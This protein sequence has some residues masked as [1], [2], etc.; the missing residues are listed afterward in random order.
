MIISPS[1]RALLSLSLAFVVL[2]SACGK[3]AET[4]QPVRAVRTMIVN[5]VGGSSE[6]EYSGEVRARVESQMGFQVP[7]KVVRRLVNVGD[8][9]KPGQVLAELDP[10]DL[11]LGAQAAM[12]ALAAAQ[13]QASQAE[14]NLKRF[15][16][17]Q[18]QGF[19]SEAQLDTYVTAA[20]AARAQLDQARAQSGVQ[21]NQARY[22]RLMA[23]AA[24]VVTA[25]MVEPGQV[26]SAGMPVITLAHDGP[27]DVVFSV[28]EDLVDA[29]RALL[30][31]SGV[32]SV[33]RWGTSE[34]LPV[35][36]REVAS[37][38]DPLARTFQIKADLGK[39][40]FA[41]GQTA[42]VRIQA[43]ARVATGLHV[44][45]HAVAEQ[46]G[47]SV[48][49]LLNPSAMTVQPVPVVLGDVLGNIV[50]VAQGLK[51]GQE[52]VTAGAHVLQPGQKVRRYD[53]TVAPQAPASAA[54]QP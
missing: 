41:L 37:S 53:P 50:L 21:S 16:E 29:A 14:A 8:V 27:R 23:T 31:K 1:H 24:G 46:G 45:L 26:V 3:P 10:S 30:G 20:R 4:P 22:A 12:A 40:P 43:P 47:R 7:G 17:L 42:T 18:Q 5:D 6:R 44:P 2:L 51:P 19:I 48:V 54:S 49:W 38:A 11:K 32:V 33:R 15:T 25:A 13:A 36:V 39:A 9:V 28:P 34:W 52:I 35:V